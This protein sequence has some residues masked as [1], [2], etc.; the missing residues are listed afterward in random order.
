MGQ[1][2]TPQPPDDL[3]KKAAKLFKDESDKEVKELHEACKI[4][5]AIKAING[6]LKTGFVTEEMPLME[7]LEKLQNRKFEL[8]GIDPDSAEEEEDDDLE[9]P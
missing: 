7:A 8:L 6:Y 4:D 5:G 1:T 2:P 3:D 9:D